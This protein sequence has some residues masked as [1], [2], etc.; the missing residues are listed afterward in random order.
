[1]PIICNNKLKRQLYLIDSVIERYSD[2]WR[3]DFYLEVVGV[4][5]VGLDLFLEGGVLRVKVG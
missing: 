3:C 2:V 4:I 5:I 1:M